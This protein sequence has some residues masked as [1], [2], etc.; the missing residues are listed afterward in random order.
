MELR[1][2]FEPRDEYLSYETWKGAMTLLK[3]VMLVKPGENVLITSDT[4]SDKRV[5]DAFAAAA[6]TLDAIPVNITY[7]TA[8][9]SLM[10]PPKP[11]QAAANEADVWFELSYQ[12]VQHTLSWQ[13]AIKNGVRYMCLTGMDVDMLNRCVSSIKYDPMI[14]FGEYLKATIEHIDKIEVKSANGTDLVAYERGRKVRHSGQRGTIKGYPFMLGGQISW[15]PIESTINGTLVFDG[16]IWPP[17]DLCVL[18]EP[19]R[20]EIK[21]GVVTK[22]SGGKEADRLSEWMASFNDPACYRVAH[23]SLGFNPGVTSPTGRIVEDE[24]VFGGM[25]FGIGSQGAAIMGEKWDAPSHTDGTILKPTL[26][27][28]GKVFE[29]DG[30]YLDEKAREYCRQMEVAGY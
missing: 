18:H 25:E 8:P 1:L 30:I 2:G 9:R 4:S 21:D 19:V 23:Y 11:I 20:L 22:I 27:F 26:I 5:A 12:T 15:S 13:D 17:N 10:D 24:R 28:D 6:Y 14:E 3:D 29:Q 7:A 16:A